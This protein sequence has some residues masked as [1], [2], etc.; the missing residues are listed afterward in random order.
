VYIRKY[1]NLNVNFLFNS[2][3]AEGLCRVS[4]VKK[5]IEPMG[6]VVKQNQLL[7]AYSIF[8]GK[9][10]ESKHRPISSVLNHYFPLSVMRT[11]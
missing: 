2:F 8:N 3:T 11:A 1:F 9:S 5:K 10:E 7:L 6:E 4:P